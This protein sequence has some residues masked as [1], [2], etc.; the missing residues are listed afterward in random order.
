MSASFR[1]VL[2]LSTVLGVLI[3]G[4][5]QALTGAGI[6]RTSLLP[7]AGTRPPIIIGD[8]GSVNFDIDAPHGS[9]GEWQPGAPGSDTV[10]FHD[11]STGT[12]DSFVVTLTNT[13][14]GGPNSANCQAVG[15]PFPVNAFTVK[16]KGL[17]SGGTV[18]VIIKNN[19]FHMTFEGSTAKKQSEPHR[20]ES[21]GFAHLRKL[22]WVDLGGGDRCYFAGNAKIDVKQITH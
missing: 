22:D 8:G 11:N 16:F 12:L 6:D 17:F 20:L 19:H 4:Y 5:G 21:E 14:H 7:A 18:A 3:W 9:G 2:L 15:H 1:K 13:I 10:W